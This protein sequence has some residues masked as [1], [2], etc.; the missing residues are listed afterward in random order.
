MQS[1]RVIKVGGKVI[2]DAS[3]LDDFLE[4]VAKLPKPWLLIHGGGALATRLSERLGLQVEMIDGRRVTDREQL[5]VVV[6]VYAGNINKTIVA[7]LNAQGCLALGLCGADGDLLRARKRPLVQGRDF[8]FVG[9]IVGVNGPL[10]QDLLN[11]GLVPV[12]APLTHDGNGQLLNTNAD[13]VAQ[14]IASSLC[15][16][17]S[18]QLIFAFDQSGVLRQAHNPDSLIAHLDYES[19]MRDKALGLW[20]GGMQ[21]KLEA[22]FRAL[23]SGVTD[24]QIRHWRQASVAGK[25]LGTQLVL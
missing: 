25:A 10:L 2:D 21:P 7:K 6:G 20:S 23:K 17:F 14:E 12:V 13:T 15:S 24:V 9:D 19:Y 1:L 4:A 16:T 3:D 5:E 11:A 22:G 18:V 8:G